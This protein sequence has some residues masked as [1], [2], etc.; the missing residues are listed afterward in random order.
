MAASGAFAE[1][2]GV[3]TD[4]LFFPGDT[5]TAAVAGVVATA[6]DATA[7]FGVASTQF[8]MPDGT[9]VNLVG[10]SL[11]DFQAGNPAGS[12]GWFKP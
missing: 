5:S 12:T 8:H 10:V 2:K 7:T 4:F 1:S 11:A 3:A 9:T 6:T